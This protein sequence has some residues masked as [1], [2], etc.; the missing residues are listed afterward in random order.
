MDERREYIKW[1]EFKSIYN[2]LRLFFS[3][4]NM[5]YKSSSQ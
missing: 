2:N 5:R 4:E 3:I 1:L